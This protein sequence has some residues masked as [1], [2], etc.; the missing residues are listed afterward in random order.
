MSSSSSKCNDYQKEHF[1]PFSSGSAAVPTP[2]HLSWLAL[3][4]LKKNEP[5]EWKRLPGNIVKEVELKLLLSGLE[6]D[7]PPVV[8]QVHSATLIIIENLGVSHVA[9]EVG[10][11]SSLSWKRL[12]RP[13]VCLP[14]S[15]VPGFGL[16]T[17]YQFW[18]I[19]LKLKAHG[20]KPKH[21]KS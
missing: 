1:I 17:L 9:K 8:I 18:W 14:S 7:L 5:R 16:C 21:F 12:Q 19:L 20:S 2:F 11:G 13:L 6:D 10:S 15:C 4:E 3:N